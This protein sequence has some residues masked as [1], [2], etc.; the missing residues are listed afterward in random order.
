MNFLN[1]SSS[2]SI[3]NVLR[4]ALGVSQQNFPNQEIGHSKA[5]RHEAISTIYSSDFQSTLESAWIFPGQ[6]SHK[7]GL[8]LDLVEIP[9]IWERFQEAKRILGWS[10]AEISQDADKLSQTYYAQ[11]WLY[12]ITTSLIDL[13]KEKSETPN[14]VLGYSLGEY[15]ALYAAEAYDWSTGL[16]LIQ[17]RAEIMSKGPQGSMTLLSNFDQALFNHKLNDISNVWQINDDEHYPI[18]AG[19][20]ESVQALLDEVAPKKVIPLA[21]NRPYHTPLME[22]TLEEFDRLLEKTPLNRLKTPMLI[23]SES[24]P[25]TSP[26]IIKEHLKYQLTNPVRWQKMSSQLAQFNTNQVIGVGPAQGILR[27]FRDYSHEYQ[28]CFCISSL[29]ELSFLNQKAA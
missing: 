11:P 15:L 24:L 29:E 12:L 23:D 6:G 3:I 2:S 10:V 7:L 13:L 9:Y 20:S 5:R 14:L 8:G 28:Q 18:I 27:K 21:V 1:Y 25:T 26:K 17:Q 22:S 4:S 16:K 19:Y